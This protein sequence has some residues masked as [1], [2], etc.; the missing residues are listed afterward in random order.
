MVNGRANSDVIPECEANGS[1]LLRRPMT[2]PP[3]TRNLEPFGK[4]PGSRWRAPRNDDGLVLSRKYP[5]PTG[6]QPDQIPGLQLP[7][8][9]RVD[10]DHGLAARQRDLGALDRTEGADMADRTLERTAAGR[11]D[12]HVMAAHEQF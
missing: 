7:V 8:P 11:P 6:L 3:R 5:V 9:G 2:A 4:I 12:L 1:A 10:L